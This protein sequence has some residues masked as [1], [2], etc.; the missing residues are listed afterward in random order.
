MKDNIDIN[1]LR[2]S[3]AHIMA[4]AV[5][6]LF[7]TVQLAFVPVGRS[8]TFNDVCYKKNK[9]I[10]TTTTRKMSC[11]QDVIIDDCKSDS[12]NTSSLKNCPNYQKTLQTAELLQI[13]A[14]FPIVPFIFF[15]Y[16]GENFNPNN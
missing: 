3:A 10:F 7:P 5:M 11:R 12:T 9:P 6:R 1:T 2:H 8:L 13:N 15:G 4:R 16:N 14:T